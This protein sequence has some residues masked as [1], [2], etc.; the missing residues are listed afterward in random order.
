M[1]NADVGLITYDWV[2][3]FESPFPNLNTR[4]TC[5][6]FDRIYEWYDRHKVSLMRSATRTKGVVDLSP[7][8]IGAGTLVE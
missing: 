8:E 7:E 2:E 4:H 5:R 6:D 3:G 1:C